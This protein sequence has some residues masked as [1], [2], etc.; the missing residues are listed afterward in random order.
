MTFDSFVVFLVEPRATGSPG[1]AAYSSTQ[2]A[3]L[4]SVAQRILGAEV[5]AEALGKPA[6]KR[7]TA[8]F[9]SLFFGDIAMNLKGPGPDAEDDCWRIEFPS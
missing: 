9:H 6:E 8:L 4:V 3:T 5:T 1:R 7:F 2:V